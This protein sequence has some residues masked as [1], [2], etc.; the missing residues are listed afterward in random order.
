MSGAQNKCR[1]R[2]LHKRR[3]CSDCGEEYSHS[4]FYTHKC[5]ANDPE[6][7]AFSL[8]FP[9]THSSSDSEFHISNLDESDKV[10]VVNEEPQFEQGSQYDYSLNDLE[11][12]R[13]RFS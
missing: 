10:P 13:Y 12:G 1:R 11:P 5:G 2:R 3:R 4:S 7:E 6:D 9:S 8:H